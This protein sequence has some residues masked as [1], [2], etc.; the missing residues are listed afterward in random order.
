MKLTVLS[1]MRSVSFKSKKSR[2]FLTIGAVGLICAL[3]IASY[4]VARTFPEE[5]IQGAEN[6]G[7]SDVP[8][9]ISKVAW[10]WEDKSVD[11]IYSAWSTQAGMVVSVS[12]RGGRGAGAIG[13]DTETGREAW[14]Y[15]VPGRSVEVNVTPD[16]QKVVLAYTAHPLLMRFFGSDEMKVLTLRASDGKILSEWT[17]NLS[18]DGDSSET[19]VKTVVGSESDNVDALTS[20][21]RLALE[22]RGEKGD[23]EKVALVARSLEDNRELWRYDGSDS[24]DLTRTFKDKKLDILTTDGNVVLTMSCGEESGPFESGSGQ[25]VGIDAETGKQAWVHSCQEGGGDFGVPSLNPA[26][27][28]MWSTFSDYDT[29]SSESEVMSVSNCGGKD[30]YLDSAS[31]DETLAGANKY[32]DEVLWRKQD[33]VV[34]EELGEKTELPNVESPD[35]NSVFART[36]KFRKVDSSGDTAAEASLQLLS[37]QRTTLKSVPLDNGMAVMVPGT[38][39]SQSFSGKH[40]DGVSAVMVPWGENEPSRVIKFSDLPYFSGIRDQIEENS[41]ILPAPG[42]VVVSEPTEDGLSRRLVGLN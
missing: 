30:V 27:N 35:G 26:M 40:E 22:A 9:G 4:F 21:A 7:A 25:I 39:P 16:R 11:K 13:I 17:D 32:A 34:T 37:N 36:T 6:S 41:L 2:V 20:N 33:F 3:G 23:P 24:C 8:S 29:P 10:S 14:S 42:A 1:R 5:H 18:T 28:N 38:L 15:R 31:G 19:P 12:G